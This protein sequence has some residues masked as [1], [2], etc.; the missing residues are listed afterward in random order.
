MKH[1]IISAIAAIAIALPLSAAS[2]FCSFFSDLQYEVNA[3]TNIGGA[4][5]IPLPREIREIKSYSPNLNL[6]LGVT[7]TKWLSPDR[8]WGVALGARMET[9]G[10]K[11]RA[12]VKNYGMEIIDHGNS[13]SGNWTGFVQTKYHTQQLVIPIT[14]VW[15][16]NK[17]LKVNFGPYLSYAFDND[18]SGYVYEG[19]LRVGNPSGTKQNFSGDSRATYDFS[20]DLRNFQWG[21]QGGVSWAAYSHLNVNANLTWGCNDIFK[22]S[23]KT[24]TFN[25]YP[26]YLNVG[27]GYVF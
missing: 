16:A 11:T 23:F 27:F 26:I 24:I 10:M 20:D 19:Y 21:F 3:G 2:G 18:F 15:Q 17:R 4:S 14:G 22:S 5:P 1:R 13:T 25:M 9:K 8:R 7:V 6:Q 12:R